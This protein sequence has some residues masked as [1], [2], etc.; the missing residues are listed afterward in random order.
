MPHK[1]DGTRID[2]IL[3]A[4]GVI[5]RVNTFQLY[6]QSITFINSRICEYLRDK[7][8]ETREHIILDIVG[9]YS[10]REA[11]E[12]GEFLN[13]SRDK[14]K[15]LDDIVKDGIYINIPPM[16][17]KTPLFD[18]ISKIYNDYPW[19][20][21]YNMFIKR[22]GKWK[23]ILRPMV[24]GKMY[25]LILKQSSKKGFS[26][27]AKGNISLKRLPEKSTIKGGY[28][29]TPVR[30]GIDENLNSLISLTPDMLAMMHL[31]YK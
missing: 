6:E 7:D 14:E 17:E 16:W 10:E 28:A 18:V 11:K 5:G 31:H 19:I 15:M 9:R 3:N 29:K 4:S 27:R 21:P 24:I 20:K 1:E 13:I 12:L 2:V 25:M 8:T 26:A 30:V 22:R 23:K